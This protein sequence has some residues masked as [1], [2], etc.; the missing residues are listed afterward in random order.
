MGD[1]QTSRTFISSWTTEPIPSLS[2]SAGALIALADLQT[3]AQRTVL[4][5]GSSW[6]DAFILAPGLHYQQA[7]DALGRHSSHEEA[8]TVVE[9]RCEG[10]DDRYP[11]SNP[12]VV[13]Y[14][15]K[16]CAEAQVD[17]VTLDIDLDEVGEAFA[18]QLSCLLGRRRKK[19]D[20]DHR[21][22]DIDWFSH[23][24]YLA[25][26]LL[27]IGALVF[28]ILLKEWWALAAV[29]ALMLARIFNIFIIKQRCKP[30]LPQPPP[31]SSEDD[32]IEY[33]VDL[34]GGRHV[35]LRG[36]PADLRAITAQTWLRDKTHM[37]GFFEAAAKLLVYLVAAFSGNLTQAGSVVLMALMLASAGLLGLSNA[38]LKSFRMHGRVARF[39][40]QRSASD[41]GVLRKDGFGYVQRST[42]L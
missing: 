28:T 6:L 25:S 41:P 39:G 22:F 35:L 24:F 10:S 29:I 11:I 3:I 8:S 2:L 12:V 27:T 7:A 32:I 15:R 31:T 21:P 36:R 33:T 13:N 34:G 20:A 5:G 4:A 14:L 38:H 17:P 19:A 37:E 16:V 42:T 26:P 1:P 23:L 9:A 30:I 40:L 18:K